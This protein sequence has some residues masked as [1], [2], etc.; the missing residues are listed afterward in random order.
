MRIAFDVH[1][2]L[3]TL[4]EYRDLLRSLYLCDHSIYI[5]SG[6]PLDD[7]MSEFLDE[8]DLTNY[9]DHY[10]SIETYLLD[11]N[12]PYTDDGSGKF[13][14]DKVWNSVKAQICHDE[15]IDMIFD[16][17]VT[18]AETFKNVNTVYSL[19][20]EKNKSLIGLK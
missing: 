14:G 12:K 6:Q 19:V 4:P 3:D 5:I 1:G 2:V 9:Y 7:E 10:F 11:L 15:R 13:F 8:Y 16:N 17:S 18:Y 20:I